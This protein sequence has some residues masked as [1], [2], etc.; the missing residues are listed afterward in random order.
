LP[1]GWS[2]IFLVLPKLD[3]CQVDLPNCLSCSKACLLNKELSIG[4]GPTPITS[5]VGNNT[6]V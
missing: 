5:C 2:P 1:N 6:G 4:K 3:R